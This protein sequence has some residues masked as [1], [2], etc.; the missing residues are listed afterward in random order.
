MP[1]GDVEFLE[2]ATPGLRARPR[3]GPN[4]IPNHPHELGEPSRAPHVPVAGRVDQRILR[5]ARPAGVRDWRGDDRAR[6]NFARAGLW[7]VFFTD[8]TQI[9]TRGD[10]ALLVLFQD[11]FSRWIGGWS[12]RQPDCFWRSCA[13]PYCDV[14]GIPG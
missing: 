12:V 3:K 4:G 14:C 8:A 6:R 11:G 10:E 9:A 2:K 1:E 13:T 5:F 7:M